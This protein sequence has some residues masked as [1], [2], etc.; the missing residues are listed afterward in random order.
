MGS[1]DDVVASGEDDKGEA[2]PE[3][4]VTIATFYFVEQAYLSKAKLQ[5]EG[6]D[7]LILGAYSTGI[8]WAEAGM[9]GP[10][11]L[12]VRESDVEEA[13]GILELTEPTAP[14]DEENAAEVCPSCGSA[15]VHEEKSR[16][17]ALSAWFLS[18][19]PPARQL[20]CGNCGHEWKVK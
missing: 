6:I 12:Q 14:V 8:S 10:V 11:R 5:S 13:M 1:D 2:V 9:V 3:E 18:S 16:V 19:A 4:L 7:S 17:K 15:D 20:R